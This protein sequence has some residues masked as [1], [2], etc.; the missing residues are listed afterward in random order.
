MVF[1]TV[2]LGCGKPVELG[3]PVTPLAKVHV[4]TSGD[5]PPGSAADGGSSTPQLHV[6]LVWGLQWLPEPFCVLP[7]ESPEVA[8]V[9]ATGCRDSF[10]FVPDR[11]GAD[12][13]LE[14]GV[15]ATLSLINFPAADV[16]VGDLTARIAYASLVVYDDRNSN[17]T[18]DVRHPG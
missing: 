1:A 8:A 14:P 18:L 10:G 16:M 7:P 9:A 11:A 3:G 5:L 2:W 6:A 15:P 12:A 4:Q 17:G 13:P